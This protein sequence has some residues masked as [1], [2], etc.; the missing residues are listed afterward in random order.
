LRRRRTGYLVA[1][2]VVGLDQITKAWAVAA[3]DEPV[4]LIG[5]FLRLAVTRNPGAAFSSFPGGGRILGVV[6]VIIIGL[7]AVLIERTDRTMEIV[8]MGMIL[9]GAAG[10]LVDRICRG[11][12]VLDGH[13]VDFFDF[14]FFPTFN[15][16]DSAISVGVVMLLLVTLLRAE[17]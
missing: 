14:S 9:G 13:V 2:G 16:A 6:A 3:L 11:T 12:G 15:V 5:D 8:T 1:A 17:P 7:L 10:N 4:H